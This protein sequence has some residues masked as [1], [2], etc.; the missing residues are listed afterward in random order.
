MKHPT[1]IFSLAMI[2]AFRMLGLFMILPVFSA[3]ATE[4]PGATATLLGVALGIYGLS[5]A[6]LQM[7][8]GMLSD[9]IGR[10]PV[11]AGGL[12]L[13]ALGS[14]VAA[15]SHSIY[16]IILG[17]ILQGA[18]AIGSTTLA[19]VSDLTRDE[20]R[21]KAMAMM[22]LTI[23][24]AFSIA[25]VLGPII[26][27]WFRLSG[28]FWATSGFAVVG[29][30]LLITVPTP[31]KVRF[32]P[33][34]ERKTNN[35]KSVFKNGQLLRLDWGIFSMHA[36]LTATFIAIPILF[37]QV[38][39]LSETHQIITY[40]VV[41]TLAFV[42]M[43]PL[44]ILA[45]KK[46]KMK[47]IFLLAIAT[48]L[49]SQSFLFFLHSS[50]IAI[51]ILLFFFFAAFTLLEASLPSLV[52][53]I[54]PIRYKGTAM[55]VYSSSQFLGIFIGGCVGGWTF[56]HFGIHGIF[57][58]CALIAFSWLIIASTMQRPPYLST[59]IFQWGP[60][61]TQDP[62][63]LSQ[64]LRSIPG[65]AEVAIITEENLIYTKVDKKIVDDNEL[66]KL[67]EEGNLGLIK[68]S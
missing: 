9:R 53:K 2:M 61:N 37:T 35:L 50:A 54:A 38:L 3:H 34:I 18:G 46:R 40:L 20:N 66:R 45:E 15:L 29:L 17:R 23:G 59:L 30:L 8:F 55:G 5:Q 65:V 4:L 36:M 57:L 60:K 43:V 22:G 12:I 26:Y 67:M 52:S 33:D 48:L 56:G 42:T 58:F 39:G 41:L 27:S 62:G 19:M 13:F 51:G 21:S 6:V 11:I 63:A 44:I 28:I 24:F 16:G 49:L 10:K 47:A 32:H 68:P 14:V 64:R 25:M 1:A 31:P 7:P